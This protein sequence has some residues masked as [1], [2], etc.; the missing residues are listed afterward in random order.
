MKRGASYIRKKRAL[1]Q[2]ISAEAQNLFAFLAKSDIIISTTKHVSVAQLDRV[3]ASD[4]VGSG[5]DSR[6]AHQ[7]KGGMHN[8]VHPALWHVRYPF[9]RRFAQVLPPAVQSLPRKPRKSQPQEKKAAGGHGPR[10]QISEKSAADKTAARQGGHS[11]VG[12]GRDTSR[13]V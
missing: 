6:R 8:F 13:S 3:T 10:E 9:C 11:A 12:S 2:K 4:A 5:F 7:K 1:R